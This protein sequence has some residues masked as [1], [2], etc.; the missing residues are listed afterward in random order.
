MGARILIV[1]DEQIIA[2][3]LALRV[4]AL[5]HNVVGF[6]ISGEKAIAVAE[7]QKPDLI[8]MDIRLRGRM[9][10][11]ECARI[12]RER[13]RVGIV[14]VTAY[15]GSLLRDRPHLAEQEICVNKPWSRP[16]LEIA[17]NKALGQRFP[18]SSAA[19]SNSQVDRPQ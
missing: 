7:D 17:I 2:E 19:S 14:F 16:Q 6:C 15:P 18:G 13:M 10:G 9:D 12:I 1:E 11:V 3:D 5:G 4:G 8:L